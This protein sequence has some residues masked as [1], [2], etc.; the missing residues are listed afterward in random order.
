MNEK[1]ESEKTWM[2]FAGHEKQE[3]KKKPTK[4]REKETKANH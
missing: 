1:R 3:K 2:L 4:K